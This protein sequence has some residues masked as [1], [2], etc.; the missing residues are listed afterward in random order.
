MVQ[1]STVYGLHGVL[2]KVVLSA[3]EEVKEKTLEPN[4]FKSKTAENV[5]ME[6]PES[7]AATLSNAQVSLSY[8][9]LHLVDVLINKIPSPE[10][11]IIIYL[12]SNS[13]L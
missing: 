3:V 13:S 5:L 4:L 2:G 1:K 6:I 9:F 10:Q 11:V 12:L 7:K 8:L